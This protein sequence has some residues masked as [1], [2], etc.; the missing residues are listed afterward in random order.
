MRC[1]QWKKIDFP[2]EILRKKQK[3]FYESF[4]VV[5]HISECLPSA[6]H[7][8]KKPTRTHDKKKLDRNRAPSILRMQL[9]LQAAKVFWNILKR[10]LFQLQP[11]IMG[12]EWVH[13]TKNAMLKLQ[14]LPCLGNNHSFFLHAGCFLSVHQ[15]KL[16]S[17]TLIG[18]N[19]V[20]T[21]EN[22]R[23]AVII[24]H[25]TKVWCDLKRHCKRPMRLQGH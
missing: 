4:S 5:N 6:L 15:K 16:S 8:G 17:N 2:T 22:M 21:Q 20:M 25:C 3:F 13:S 18:P 1:S 11:S 23:N 12:A 9:Q 7:L 24:R 19:C 14:C 10:K